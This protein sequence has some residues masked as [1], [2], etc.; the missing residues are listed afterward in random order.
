M[1][2][3]DYL[4][5][6][7]SSYPRDV[8]DYTYFLD[9]IILDNGEEARPTQPAQLRA[10]IRYLTR[11]NEDRV[12]TDGERRA[13]PLHHRLGL[14]ERHRLRLTETPSTSPGW[15]QLLVS[16]ACLAPPKHQRHLLRFPH[17]LPFMRNLYAHTSEETT[18]G[19]P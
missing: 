12:S 18:S 8:I 17:Q 5:H 4:D 14:S 13:P 9:P 15:H 19:Q 16:C 6:D 1:K 10:R 2:G 3:H 7:D 11:N